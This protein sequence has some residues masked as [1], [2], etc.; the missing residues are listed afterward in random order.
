MV[1]MTTA[2]NPDAEA[3]DRFA[4]ELGDAAAVGVPRWVQRV[5]A[6]RWAQW[7]DDP[8]S[9]ELEDAVREAADEAATAVVDP[10]RVLLATDVAEQRTSPLEVL[11]RAVVFPTRV[12]AAAGLPDVQRDVDAV[13]LFPDDP[14]DLT[15]GSFAD[16]DEGLHEPGLKWGAAKAHIL[17]F[18]HRP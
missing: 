13:R 1:G 9:P 15:P 5:V 17:K 10:L 18:R 11:R 12:L 4:Q 14:Y 16:I 2:A 7:T 6:E 3:M 8:L